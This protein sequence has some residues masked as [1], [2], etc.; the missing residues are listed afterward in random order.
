M[1]IEETIIQTVNKAI[2]ESLS[3]ISIGANDEF[4]EVMNVKQAAKFLNCGTTWIYENIEQIPHFELSGYKFLKS[5]LV[6]WCID[7]TGR[8]F[9]VVKTK[10]KI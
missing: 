8:S 6:E 2:K 7:K 3:S 4:P 1:S 5:Q 10:I 9:R